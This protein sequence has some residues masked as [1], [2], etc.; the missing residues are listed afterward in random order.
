MKIAWFDTETTG[1]DPVKND[2][3]QLAMII[4]IDGEIKEKIKMEMQPFSYDNISPEALETNK[5]T[6]E[7]IKTFPAPQDQYKIL[8]KIL[9]NHVDRYNKFDKMIAGGQNVKFDIEFLRNFFIKNNDPYFG[10]FFNYH[11]VDIISLSA[12]LKYFKKIDIDNLKLET[13]CE[14]MGI[15]LSAH[16]AMEDITATREVFMEFGKIQLE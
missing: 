5:L 6:I 3:I 16:D 7:Q 10:S 15:E 4:E 12:I 14:Y 2:I 8:N 1:L 11:Y 13:I 9:G